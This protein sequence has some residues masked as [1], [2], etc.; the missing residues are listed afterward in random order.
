MSVLKESWSAFS[1]EIAKI[2]L[3][4][5]GYPSS[6]SKTLVASLLREMFADRRFRIADFGCG[7][8][9]MCRHFRERGLDCEYFGYEFSASLLAAARERFAEDPNAHFIEA[10]IGDHE[11]IVEPCDVV[12]FSHVIEMLPSPERSLI[13]AKRT[14]PIIMIRFFEPPVAEYDLTELRQMNVSSDQRMVPYLRRTMSRDYYN[15]VLNKIGCRSV[16]VHQ[17][18]GDKDQVHLLRFQ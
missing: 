18:D 11:L 14:A 5:F 7:N 8:G 6:L 16:E 12:L 9:H 1:P 17:V 4:G 10:D 3:D 15:L 13:A 2:Y